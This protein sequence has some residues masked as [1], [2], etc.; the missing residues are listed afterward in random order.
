MNKPGE[1]GCNQKSTG[2]WHNANSTVLTNE[3]EFLARAGA[4]SSLLI[5]API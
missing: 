3:A 4:F 1:G 5:A 2:Y